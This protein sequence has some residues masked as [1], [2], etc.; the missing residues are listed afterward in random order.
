[1]KGVILD[2]ISSP[3][4]T[5]TNINTIFKFIH[6]SQSSCNWLITGF[7][8]YP[9]PPRLQERAIGDAI[10]ISG[11]EL[12]EALSDKCYFGYWGV[13]SCFQKNILLEEIMHYSSPYA[14][15]YTGFW[16][17][18]ISIQHPL[19]HIELVL[20]DGYLIL[21]ISKDDCVIDSFQHAYPNAQDLAAYNKE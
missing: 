13:F 21:L 16:I 4:T 8:G 1:M 2:T 14:D 20:W 3:H 10:W 15:G 11:N 6:R 12:N 19:A 18:P 9:L 5:S 17:N 7:E